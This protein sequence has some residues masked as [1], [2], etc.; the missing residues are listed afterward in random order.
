MTHI[1]ID[2][3]TT[4]C[5]VIQHTSAGDTLVLNGLGGELT[6]SVV[7]FDED[8]TVLVGR[9]AQDAGAND[10]ENLVAGIKRHMG[11][12]H[13]L[14]FHGHRYTPEA[15]SAVILRQLVADAGVQLGCAPAGIQCVITVPAYFGVAEKEATFAAAR[16]SGVR[17]LELLAEPVAAAY[18]Y[19]HSPDQGSSL[20]FDLG[21][22]TFDVA[23][24]GVHQGK[25][26]IWAVDGETQLGGLDWDRRLADLLWA[27]LRI[28]GIDEDAEFDEEFAIRVNSA[29]ELLKR[30]LTGQASATARLRRHGKLLT[31]TITRVAFEDSTADL[32]AQCVEAAQRVSDT[33]RTLCA[34]PIAQILLVGG[35]TRM[36]MIKEALAARFGL[37]VLI[38]DPDKAVARGAAVLAEKLVAQRP[39]IRGASERITSVLPRAIG[40]KTYSS[41]LPARTEPYVRNLLPANTPLPIA[42]RKV[43]V[44][45]IVQDQPSAR[46]E[47][48]EQAGVSASEELADNRLFFDGEVVGI[49]PG[50]AGSPIELTLSADAGGRISV[51]AAHGTS[52][53]PLVVNAFIH[54]VIDE[55]ELNEQTTNVAR[56]SR[57][58]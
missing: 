16:I 35:S 20:V 32:V 46:I 34:A 39:G 13:P 12:D 43:K 14:E 58:G 30:A 2:L 56:L 1:G 33:S 42:A 55:D 40:I 26:R 23:V 47:L 48:Y 36:P 3:G 27:R 28:D 5:C 37:P 31:V 38:H 19:G 52:L 24:V 18:A 15:I 53:A 9:E 49:P 45:T 21:G 17:C 54:G 22:G 57:L 10:P 29:A 6:P 41:M 7:Y 51:A 50:P 44:G 4:Y 11:A 25:P 8:G